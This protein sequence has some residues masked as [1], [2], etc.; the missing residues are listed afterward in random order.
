MSVS[1]FPEMVVIVTNSYAPPVL[2]DHRRL[3]GNLTNLEHALGRSPQ[4][5]EAI[6]DSLWQCSIIGL[7]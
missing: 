4:A 6:P 7:M 1:P 3:E 5:V 2:L